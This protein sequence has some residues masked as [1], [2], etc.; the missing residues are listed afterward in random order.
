MWVVLGETLGKTTN[1]RQ[2]IHETNVN[3]Q[4][5]A[6]SHVDYLYNIMLDLVLSYNFIKGSANYNVYSEVKSRSRKSLSKTTIS[7]QSINEQNVWQL[8]AQSCMVYLR[9]SSDLSLKHN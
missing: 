1:S 3:L 8:A 6:K 4:Q 9:I 5:A 2:A 7:R